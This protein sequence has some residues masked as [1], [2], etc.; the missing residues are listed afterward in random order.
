M[1]D[2]V[3]IVTSGVNDILE[4]LFHIGKGDLLVAISFPRYA[5]RAVEAMKFSK[6]QGAHTVA[7]TDS[8][9]SPLTAYADHSLLARSDMVSF[10]DSLVA[11]LSL[12]N[13]LIVAIGQS[14]KEQIS[15]S[16][17]KLENIWEE[18]QVYVGKNKAKHSDKD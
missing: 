17:Q 12:I 18:Y 7:I 13:A 3:K 15:K 5:S 16:F 11:P 9:L 2:N 1:F 4:Q 6:E 10:V 14:R 8:M